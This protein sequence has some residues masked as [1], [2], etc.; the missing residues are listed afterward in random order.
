M[1]LVIQFIKSLDVDFEGLN[2]ESN[3]FHL[4]YLCELGGKVLFQY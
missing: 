3:I 2:Y 4:S 1:S